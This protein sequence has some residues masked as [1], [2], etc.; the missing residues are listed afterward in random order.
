MPGLAGPIA[1]GATV[2]FTWTTYVPVTT[3]ILDD[4]LGAIPGGTLILQNENVGQGGAGCTPNSSTGS[5]PCYLK[6]IFNQATTLND[7]TYGSSASSG[8]GSHGHTFSD[9]TGSDQAWFYF[10]DTAGNAVLEDDEDYISQASA[11][12]SGCPWQMLNGTINT[13]LYPTG[14]GTLG[15]CG[16]DGKWIGGSA[17]DTYVVSHDSTLTDDLNQSSAYYGYTANSPATTDPNYSGWNIV[18]GYTLVINPAAF[19]SNGFGWVTN[20]LIHN[21]PSKNGTDQ[22][23]NVPMSSTATNTATLTAPGLTTITTT[24]SVVVTSSYTAAAPNGGGGPGPGGPGGPGGP[25]PGGPGPGGPAGPGAPGALK[26]TFPAGP[27]IN[28]TV[29]TAYSAALAATGGTGPYTFAVTGGSLP[30]GLTLNANTGA[31]TGILTTMTSGPG[32]PHHG[33]SDGFEEGNRQRVGQ[34]QHHGPTPDPE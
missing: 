26:L 2:T 3:M 15:W 33:H 6:M 5:N 10:Y 25:A 9:L 27:A 32:G 16:G 13:T 22:I 21:S 20:P 30:A 12:D 28:G 4:T 17:S 19:G 18:D 7:N 11:P 1:S 24:A 8:W 23:S 34:H 29:N 14:Y 31:M